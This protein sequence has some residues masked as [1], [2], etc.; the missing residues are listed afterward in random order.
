MKEVWQPARSPALE[1]AAWPLRPEAKLQC[2]HQGHC[3][4]ATDPVQGDGPAAKRRDGAA[5]PRGV[6]PSVAG[7]KGSGG[8]GAGKWDVAAPPPVDDDPTVKLQSGEGDRNSVT[9]ERGQ[10]GGRVGRRKFRRRM[11]FSLIPLE[12]RY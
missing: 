1:A 9:T 6:G 10:E 8:G 4:A 11:G 2:P 5:T 7:E 3:S 12:R